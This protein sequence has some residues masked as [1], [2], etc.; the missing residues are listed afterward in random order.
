MV[1]QVAGLN[2]TFYLCSRL[3][4]IVAMVEIGALPLPSTFQDFS[5]FES[6]VQTMFDIAILTIVWP[7]PNGSCSVIIP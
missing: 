2:T 4:G 1:F 3:D 7:C 6:Q 5:L